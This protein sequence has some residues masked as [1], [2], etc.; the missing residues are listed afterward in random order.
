VAA[1]WNSLELVILYILSQ[2]AGLKFSTTVALVAPSNF[3]AWLDMLRRL[4]KR[5]KSHS[6]KEEDLKGICQKLKTL[7]TARNSVVHAVWQEPEGIGLSNIAS[8]LG[9]PKRGLS[10][11]L[12]VEKSAAD[13]RSIAKSIEAGE[14][15]LIAWWSQ[16]PPTIALST[17][18]QMYRAAQN[19]R[20][21]IAKRQ[22]QP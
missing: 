14:R 5:S 2:L 13:M 10:I 8:G 22:S 12:E 21:K 11:I 19:P 15:E 20:P 4:A 7:Q 1:Q 6:W 18:G 9:F 16:Q 3:A 17:V